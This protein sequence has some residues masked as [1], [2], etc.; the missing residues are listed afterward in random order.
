MFE[1][2]TPA[3]PEIADAAVLADVGKNLEKSLLF[4]MAIKEMDLDYAMKSKVVDSVGDAA[5]DIKNS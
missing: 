4:Q 1:I 2:S 5:G 3:S